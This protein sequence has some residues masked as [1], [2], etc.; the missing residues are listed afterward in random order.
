MGK[1]NEVLEVPQARQVGFGELDYLQDIK[2]N[3]ELLQTINGVEIWKA[4]ASHPHVP[5][6]EIPAKQGQHLVL[7][8]LKDNGTKEVAWEELLDN[9]ESLQAFL[10]I[11]QSEVSEMKTSLGSQ[12][13]IVA[14]LHMG[15]T[16]QRPENF[17]KRNGLQSKK[18]VHAYVIA[19]PDK[20]KLVAKDVP[21]LAEKIGDYAGRAVT[22]EFSEVLVEIADEFGGQVDWIDNGLYKRKVI[23][24]DNSK[25]MVRA[26]EKLQQLAMNGWY[27][28]TLEKIL[29]ILNDPANGF[30]KD[31]LATLTPDFLLQLPIPPMLMMK[32]PV[33]EKFILVPFVA[34][35]SASEWFA[36]RPISRP[37]YKIQ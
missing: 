30:D 3:G 24:F 2:D 14:G 1:K 18:A 25:E 5:T 10:N 12:K 35:I 34:G 16:D 7:W 31:L 6:Q 33:N 9:A 21:G 13:K 20:E 29:A 22:Q 26:A 37:D 8:T 36:K 15:Y 28:M 23:L 32:I 19:M 17:L 27:E 4:T 11:W